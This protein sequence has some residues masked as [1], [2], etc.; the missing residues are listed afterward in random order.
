[1]APSEGKVKWICYPL[2]EY[3]IQIVL[4]GQLMEKFSE[5]TDGT[6]SRLDVVQVHRHIT[7]K[8]GILFPKECQIWKINVIYSMTMNANK[9]SEVKFASTRILADM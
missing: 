5:D 9:F 8:F 1:M 7:V 2:S 4:Q 3:F 6:A